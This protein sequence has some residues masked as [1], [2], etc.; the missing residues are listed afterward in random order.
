M[1]RGEGGL[2]NIKNEMGFGIGR[3]VG[4]LASEEGGGGGKAASERTVSGSEMLVA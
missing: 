2:V 4:L 3:V 1:S